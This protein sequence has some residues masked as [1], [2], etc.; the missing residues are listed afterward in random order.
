[1][2]AETYVNQIVKK[3]KCSKQKREEIRRQLLSD[4]HMEMDQGSSFEAVMLRIGEP[5]A[6]AEE[7]NQ[8]LSDKEK[9][10]FKRRKTGKVLL[11]AAI[12]LAFLAAAAVWFFP[13]GMEFGSSGIFTKEQVEEQ[14]KKVIHLLDAEDY[15]AVR[16]LSDEKL[17]QLL[18]NELIDRAKEQTGKDWGA[19]IDFGKCYMAEQKQ[20]GK[21]MSIVQMNAAYENIGVTYTLFFNENM[22]LTGLYMK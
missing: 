10:R 9:K 15:E 18:T 8:G 20:Q 4:I 6:V 13:K 12:V 22:E 3:V 17:K 11:I 21:V 16:A 2:T 5:I 1:M 7:F 19:F 14:S